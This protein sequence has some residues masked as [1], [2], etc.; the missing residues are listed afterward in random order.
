M[1]ESL[2]VVSFRTLVEN[3]IRMRNAKVSENY[4][5]KSRRRAAAN[6]RL[7]FDVAYSSDVV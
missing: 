5:T 4:A 6:E 2:T 3:S 1:N 7:M